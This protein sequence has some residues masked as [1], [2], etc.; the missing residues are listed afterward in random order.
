MNVVLILNRKAAKDVRVVVHLQ[1]KTLKEKVIALLEE[2]RAREAFEL[3]LLKAKVVDYLPSG[4]KPSV[5]PE[6]IL[7]EDLL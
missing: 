3:M 5:K 2:D 4:K 6:M 7:M 1:T